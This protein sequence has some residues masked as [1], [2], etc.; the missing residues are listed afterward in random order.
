[1]PKMSDR[2]YRRKIEGTGSTIEEISKEKIHCEY[3][4]AEMICG[5][6]AQHNKSTR[7]KEALSSNSIS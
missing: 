6:I 7:S 1:M 2:A 4:G 5:S 3:F